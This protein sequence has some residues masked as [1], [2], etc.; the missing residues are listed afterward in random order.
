MATGERVLFSEQA[1]GLCMLAAAV[2][3]ARWCYHNPGAVLAH[4]R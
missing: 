1:C 2:I 4:C 3:C